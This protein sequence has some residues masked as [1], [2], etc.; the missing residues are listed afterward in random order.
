[1][2]MKPITSVVSFE[3]C[4]RTAA[5]NKSLPM[6][7]SELTSQ[8][9]I[10]NRYE[11]F[12]LKRHLRLI[13]RQHNNYQRL[14]KIQREELV[15]NF[16]SR[17]H[18]PT[19]SSVPPAEEATAGGQQLH[20]ADVDGQNSDRSNIDGVRRRKIM[21]NMEKRRRKLLADVTE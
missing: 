20:I 5:I 17:H 13:E 8:V 15:A 19:K 18:I 11:T 12:A 7:F 14:L 10:R 6:R 9:S 1:M 21:D 16:W 4:R 3:T 2:A